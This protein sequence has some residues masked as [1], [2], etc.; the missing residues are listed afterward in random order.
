MLHG[1][2][3][4]SRELDGR[5]R[6]VW[7]WLNWTAAIATIV[8]P[9]IGFGIAFYQISDAKQAAKDAKDAAESAEKAVNDAVGSFKSRSVSGLIP[10]LL[11]LGSI[12]ETAVEHKSRELLTHAIFNWRWQADLCREMLKGDDETERTVMVLIQRSTTAAS[13]LKQDMMDFN[14]TTDWAATTRRLRMAVE[15]VIGEL[16][17]LSAK[18]VVKEDN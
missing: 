6:L 1:V 14:T 11:Q 16:S 12:I 5:G 10:Q 8:L 2:R 9:I 3:R 17:S 18:Y 13:Q 15:D 4:R 7:G